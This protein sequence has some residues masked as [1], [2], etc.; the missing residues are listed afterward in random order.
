MAT[1]IIA[2]R[3]DPT[4]TDCLATF[5]TGGDGGAEDGIECH[6]HLQTPTQHAN[7]GLTLG[8]LKC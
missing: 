2:E 6:W 7:T 1:L 3:A 4:K 8:G 5:G